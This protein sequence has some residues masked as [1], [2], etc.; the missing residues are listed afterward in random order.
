MIGTILFSLL[1]VMV[2]HYHSE[3]L[4]RLQRSTT[5][6]SGQSSTELVDILLKK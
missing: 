4:G 1:V 5:D 3:N 2:V 6:L